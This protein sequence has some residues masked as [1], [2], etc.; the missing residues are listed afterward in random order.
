MEDFSL[1][2][3]IFL[4]GAVTGCLIA[5]AWMSD[6]QHSEPNESDGWLR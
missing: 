3:G 2:L 6:K 5:H 4:L 1:M